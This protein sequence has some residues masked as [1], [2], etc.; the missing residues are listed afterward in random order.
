MAKQNMGNDQMGDGGHRG[1][2]PAALAIVHTAL[3][4]AGIIATAILTGGGH[5][6]SPFEAPESARA[7][8]QTHADAIRI[9]ALL[10]F[11]SAIP[12]GLFTATV[13]HRLHYLGMN[14]AGIFIALFGG[15]GASLFLLLSG[16]A[17]W[18]I[19]QPGMADDLSTVRA[20]QWLT[21]GSGGPAYVVLIGLLLAG[22]SVPSMVGRLLPSWIP[23][24]G[25]IAAGVA[26][27]STFTLIIPEATY[28]LPAAR[29]ASL[30]WLIATGLTLPRS[31]DEARRR[32]AE[33]SAAMA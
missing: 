16:L 18:I 7:F 22:V 33:V 8:F 20:L 10:A 17:Q 3:F 2:N 9:N 28:L 1:P 19:A 6:P 32:R 26:E 15:V 29:L 4:A 12:L 5:F 25:L 24:L 23:W 21:F 14:V 11:G 30:V 13:V 31:R 27:L